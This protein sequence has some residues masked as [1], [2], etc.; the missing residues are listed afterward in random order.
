M[1][2]KVLGLPFA[3][4]AMQRGGVMA[5]ADALPT[6]RAAR[7]RAA[8]ERGAAATAGHRGVVSIR[9][10]GSETPTQ[11]IGRIS[12][13]VSEMKT[14]QSGRLD[15]LEASMGSIEDHLNDQALKVAGVEMNGGGA[16]LPVDKDC[17]AAFASYTRRVPR[18]RK[19]R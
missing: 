6:A 18:M 10:Q 16:L 19:R 11:M 4:A 7:L 14:A 15:R 9:A 2:K 13:L 12:A 17:S 8:L 3:M 1:M 5:A